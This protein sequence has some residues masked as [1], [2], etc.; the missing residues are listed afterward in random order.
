[1]CVCAGSRS[2]NTL[3]TTVSDCTSLKKLV[4]IPADPRSYEEI[5]ADELPTPED[6]DAMEKAA[7][8]SHMHTNTHT[9]KT[10]TPACMHIF[11]MCRNF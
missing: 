11:L 2:Q 5:L 1:M 3:N 4:G 7:I 6:L 9:H 10:T 8:R